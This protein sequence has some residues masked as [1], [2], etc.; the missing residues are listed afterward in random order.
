M[1]PETDLTCNGNNSGTATAAPVGTAPFGYS[2]SPSGGTSQTASNLP[3]GTYTVTMT[4]ALGCT[5]QAT[6]TIT[7][8][9]ALS[10]TPTPT[11]VT[12]FGACNGQ[13]VVSAASG[14]TTPYQYN[15]NAGAFG[16]SSTFTNLCSGSYNLILQD[17]NGCQ[18][19]MAGIAVNEP[20]AL[21]LL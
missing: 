14:G 20:T 17:N 11:D 21:T 8:P 9:T 19:V 5:D 16:G 18:F 2:W 15:I 1:I 7:E 3:A 6:V 4:D 13:I 10:A 12:C